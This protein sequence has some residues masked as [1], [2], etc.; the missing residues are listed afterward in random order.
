MMRLTFYRDS[1]GEH[2]W[3]LRARNGLVIAAATEG[4]RRAVDCRKNAQTVT[5]YRYRLLSIRVDE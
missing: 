3:R 4:Y 5:H 2:R 1:A